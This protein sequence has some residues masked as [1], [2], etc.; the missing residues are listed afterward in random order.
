MAVKYVQL[1]L[2]IECQKL[3]VEDCGKFGPGLSVPVC[4]VHCGN[5]VATGSAI[6]HDNIL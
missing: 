2:G 4:T 5:G 3:E 6:K 1:E